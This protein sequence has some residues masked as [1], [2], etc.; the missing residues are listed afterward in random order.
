MN[1]APRLCAGTCTGLALLA[2]VG[3]IAASFLGLN[4]DSSG[5]AVGMVS[6]PW[7]LLLRTCC[8][9]QVVS[10]LVETWQGIKQAILH[11]AGAATGYAI[12]YISVAVL[13]GVIFGHVM[14]QRPDGIYTGFT[15]N[16]GD[17]PFHLQIISSF[18]HGQN[19]PPEDP[20]FS[21]VR[22]AYPFV[23]DVLTAML[24][25]SGASLIFAMWIQNF[26]L[27]LA[28]VGM[29][30][31]WTLQLTRD[32]LAG[33]IAPLLVLLS[34]GLG[35]W[36]LFGDAQA[37]DSGL[38]GVLQHLPRDYTIAGDT[39]WRW[40]NSLTTLFIPQRSI[41]FGVPLAVFIF[42]QWW[43]ALND[44]EEN[45]PAWQALASTDS[46]TRKKPE[47]KNWEAASVT[48]PASTPKR[49]S[50]KATKARPCG[51]ATAVAVHPGVEAENVLV[52]K[53]EE[54]ASPASG[55]RRRMIA[56]GVFA[57]MLPLVH[58]HSFIVV[59]GMAGCLA[60][61]FPQ[62]G[63][64]CAVFCAGVSLALA[65]AFLGT[66]A[67]RT[68]AANALGLWGEVWCYTNSYV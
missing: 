25:R 32:R 53:A 37:S 41:L 62:W 61:L 58:A 18:A 35:W 66:T 64:P 52:L 19:F 42:S 14:F 45:Q 29:M 11:P 23:S 33:V 36:L 54:I 2:T 16:L 7:F 39:I 57:R 55:V 50:S 17:L 34:G 30:H 1:F 15:N 48:T 40:G 31:Y 44:G 5:I 60:L 24:V 46:G 4:T 9:S 28:L 10:D 56:A 65:A 8:R 6:L 21:G 67:A 3:F 49:A 12:F 63:G 38:V 22:F 59:M 13:L 51:E 47:T 20:A 27:G 26:A 68:N 43:L